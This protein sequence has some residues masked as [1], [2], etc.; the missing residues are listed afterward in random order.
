MSLL[1]NVASRLQDNARARQDQRKDIRLAR[2]AA[3]AETKQPDYEH[4]IDPN[5]AAWEGGA[6]MVGNVAD[7]VGKI[8]GGAATGAV[9]GAGSLLDGTKGLFGGSSENQGNQQNKPKMNMMLILGG[10]VVILF[11]I[12]K[13]K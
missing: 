13:K 9:G 10:A 5:K 1:G 11:L 2:I 3:R 8:Y 12:F 6:S 7:V 4:G